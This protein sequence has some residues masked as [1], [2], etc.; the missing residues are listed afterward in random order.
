MNRRRFLKH[1]GLW[2][3]GALAFPAIVRA[4][5][6][7][8]ARRVAAPTPVSGGAAPSYL[9]DED[10]EGSGLPTGWS[11]L[12][13]G[14]VRN[15]DYTG[16]VLEGTESFYYEDPGASNWVNVRAPFTAQDS[17]YCSFRVQAITSVPPTGSYIIAENSGT[18]IGSV[19]FNATS[20]NI[21]AF[22]A[23][24]STSAS[25]TVVLSTSDWIKVKFFCQK[26]TGS[27]AVATVWA[28]TSGGGSWGTG[29]SSTNGTG[30]A[31][32]NDISFYWYH[33]AGSTGLVVDK[34][35]VSTSDIAIGDA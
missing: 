3:T 14:G 33:T 28:A 21:Q 24:G 10:F 5:V 23:G 34:V 27:N 2:V 12:S 13:T 6:L 20:G 25:A 35:L 15:F 32:I 7:P 30:T 4:A 1:N 31:Q 8:S 26:G 29:V 9:I 16:T 19:R 18:A 17:I 22:P 11:D